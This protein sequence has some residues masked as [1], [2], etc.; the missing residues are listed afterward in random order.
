MPN[1]YTGL[2][3]LRY[4]R[5]VNDI[6]AGGLTKKDARVKM[7]VKFEKLNPTKVNPDP[8][9]IQFRDAKYCVALGR[10][11]KP[12]EHAL[13]NLSGDGKHF[14]ATRLIGKGLSQGERAMLLKQKMEQFSDPV[15]V[16]LDA[17]RFDQHVDIDLLRIEHMIY[18]F[19][20]ADPFFAQLLSWQLVNYGT[21]S[22]GV[23]YTA[24]GKRMS[25]DM[26]TALGNCILMVLMIATFMK[27]KRWDLL[28]DGDDALLIVERALLPWVLEN[29]HKAFLEFGMEVKVE[30]VAYTLATVNWCQGNPIEYQPGKWKFVR[31]PTKVLSSALGGAKYFTATGARR[32][33][34]NTIGMA[35]MVLNLGVPVLQEYAVA[36]MRNAATTKSINL[37]EVDP[38]YFRLHRELKAMNMKQLFRLDP[39]PITDE[40]RLSYSEAFGVDVEEQVAMER[41]LKG[42][43]F[44]LD[45]DMRLMDDLDVAQWTLINQVGPDLYATREC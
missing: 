32:K 4:T 18:T 7:F 35:E 23:K 42:W 21:T 17:S 9:A 12:L 19:M 1:S 34:V 13:Y 10:Y 14:P 45:G 20:C 15:V 22:K 33:L 43:T 31:D 8:R 40:A 28:D 3:K 29:V 39:Q 41:F 11:L 37:D 30:D 16:S 44:N 36:L 27:G 6:L 38:T 24:R 2:K 5:A 26:N 25:G